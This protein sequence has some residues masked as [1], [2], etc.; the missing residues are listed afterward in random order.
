MQRDQTSAEIGHDRHLNLSL[1]YTQA[2]LN[3]RALTARSQCA[4]ATL[5]VLGGLAVAWTVVQAVTTGDYARLLSP[6]WA[7]TGISILGFF[8]TLAFATRCLR[9]FELERALLARLAFLERG[10][11]S[12]C[13]PGSLDRHEDGGQYQERPSR[14][15]VLVGGLS[16]SHATGAAVALGS[17]LGAWIFPLS[18]AALRLCTVDL[19]WAAPFGI[20]AGV[21]AGVRSVREFLEQDKSETAKRLDA[22]E[23]DRPTGRRV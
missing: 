13:T 6:L 11:R 7:T 19:R 3:L 8:L 22:L 5:C 21:T 1:E 16:V 18:V 14:H 15:R 17:L 10:F 12:S 9:D 4:L 20:A 23:R 2:S